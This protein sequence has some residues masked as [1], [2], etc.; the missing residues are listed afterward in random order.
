MAAARLHRHYIPGFYRL[1]HAVHDAA[2]AAGDHVPDLVP[3]F[4]AVIV[5]PVSGVQRHLDAHALIFH[6]QYA[7]ASPGFLREHDLLID[8]VHI[9]LDI[10]GLLFV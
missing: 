9:G 10:A 2:S 1:F 5:H 7:K 3:P 6:V 4:M 8:L